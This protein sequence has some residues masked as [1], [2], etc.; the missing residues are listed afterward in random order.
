MAVHRAYKFRQSLQ[1][2]K[3]Q[4]ERDRRYGSWSLI[5]NRP[6]TIPFVY[7]KQFPVGSSPSTLRRIVLSLTNYNVVE[8]N[9]EL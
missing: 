4:E 7:C 9:R 2:G 6:E 1:G 5:L 8:F 3:G